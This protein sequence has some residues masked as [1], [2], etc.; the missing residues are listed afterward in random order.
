MSRKWLSN[1]EI[2]RG[3]GISQPTTRKHIA[4]DDFSSQVPR[5]Y[6]NMTI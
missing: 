4:M 6:R 3:A 1:A 2:Q 5:A